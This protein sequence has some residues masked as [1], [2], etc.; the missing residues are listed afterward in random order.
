MDINKILLDLEIINQI[1]VD[2]KLAVVQEKGE[3]KLSVDYSSYILPIKRWYY[4]Y[5]RN[6]T[7]NYLEKMLDNI[8]KS[9]NIIING[10]HTEIGNLLKHSI[11][12]SLS[13]FN[14]LKNTYKNDSIIYSKITL[15]IN[16]L[17]NI[18]EMLEKFLSPNL[19]I[20]ERIENI[21]EFNH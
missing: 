18:N 13:G 7:I 17:K 21:S 10:N 2:D 5:K 19:D 15:I 12:N 3:T 1:D 11:Q 8:E 6:D 14:N 16:K 4:G 9:S 20:L